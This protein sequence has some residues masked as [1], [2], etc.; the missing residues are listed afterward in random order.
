MGTRHI[1]TVI[2]KDGVVKVSQYGQWD[3]YPDGQGIDILDFLLNADL[4]KYQEE[5]N[6]LREIT[7]EDKK[8]LEVNNWKELYPHMSRDCGAE[9]HKLIYDGKVEFIVTKSWEDISAWIE[10][11]YII[12]FQKNEFRT[13]FNGY[14]KAYPLDNLPTKEQYLKDYKD[15]SKED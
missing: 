5:V 12:N 14:E 11:T 3:G 9:V 8:L 6:K 15:Y 4:E 2:N 10:G 7:E 1:Q 13:Q